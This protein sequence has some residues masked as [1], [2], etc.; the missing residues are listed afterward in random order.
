G[1][2]GLTGS[3]TIGD[4]AGLPQITGTVTIVDDRTGPLS[5]S[6]NSGSCTT[7]VQAYSATV[8]IAPDPAL[9]PFAAVTGYSLAVDG[10]QVARTEYG[11]GSTIPIYSTCDQTGPRDH[12]IPPGAHTL[13]VAAH[14]AGASSD[15]QPIQLDV[16][17]PRCG[18]GGCS[19]AAS[20]RSG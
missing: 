11:A 13:S 15:P 18:S 20:H 8:A 1:V 10:R 19:Y 6:T 16:T 12:G 2:G 9:L 3:F 14:I 7:E 4:A 5:V 17:L